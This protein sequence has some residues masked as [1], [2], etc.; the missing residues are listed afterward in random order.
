[1]NGLLVAA[2]VRRG[3]F[4]LAVELQAR[5]GETI[6]VLGQIGAGKSSVLAL[7]AGVLRAEAGS[8]RGPDGM[9]DDPAA[10][11]WLPPERRPL[12]Y[13]AARS[14]LVDEIPVIDQVVAA[15][16]GLNGSTSD[17]PRHTNGSAGARRD[18]A[19][20]LLEELGLPASVAA[21]EGWTLSGGETQRAVLARTF[22]AAQA[23]VVLDDPFQALD[24]RSGD[25][26][27][28]WL[29]QRLGSAAHVTV[30]ACSDPRDTEHL[31]DRVID[32]G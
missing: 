17:A 28:R 15:T 18:Q 20:A 1:M 6:G 30:L 26:V 7:I 2:T 22:A 31:A 5:A 16:R 9:W 19:A 24:S 29:T 13:L 27:R 10:G 32:L 3:S 14:T 23:V 21:R 8:V 4:R 25:A 12:A 11:I